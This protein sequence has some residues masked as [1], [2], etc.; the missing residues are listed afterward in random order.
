MHKPDKNTAVLVFI[1]SEKE[2]AQI[3]KFGSCLSFKGNYQIAAL[4]NKRVKAIAKKS[5][6]PTVVVSGNQQKGDNFERSV[7]EFKK[8]TNEL[9]IKPVK[10]NVVEMKPE[11]TKTKKRGRCPNGMKRNKDGE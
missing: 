2:E 8:K 10:S 7:D 3:K 11:P 4:L 9:E 1:R 6:L 5:G